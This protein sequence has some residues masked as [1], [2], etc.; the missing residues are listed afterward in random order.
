MNNVLISF[1]NCDGLYQNEYDNRVCKLDDPDVSGNLLKH[2]IVCL[3]ETHC[4]YS[5]T[6]T[7]PGFSKP[8]QNI[9]VKSP[10]AK[11]HFGGLAV[12]VKESIRRGVKF[13]PI[14]NSEY[15]WFKLDKTFFQMPNDIYVC[16]MYISNTAFA[17][18]NINVFEAVETD[19]A[20]F[21]NDGSHILLCGDINASTA[22]EP[23][24]CVNDDCDVFASQANEYVPYVQ[25]E[26][27]HRNNIN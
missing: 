15:M 13:L 1:W 2:S 22:T 4:S 14:N 8:V 9:R 10:N 12:F 11:K 21:S 23:D 17:E 26:P 7:L 3:A 19:A 25:D 18:T 16:V 24:F 5:D 6:P 27:L 20:K